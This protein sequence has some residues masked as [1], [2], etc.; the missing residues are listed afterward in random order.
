MNTTMNQQCIDSTTSKLQKET[1]KQYKTRLGRITQSMRTFL[2]NTINNKVVY[3][4]EKMENG[5]VSID[6]KKIVQKSKLAELLSEYNSKQQEKIYYSPYFACVGEFRHIILY[7]AKK[8]SSNGDTDFGDRLCV[9]IL[10]AN[11]FYTYYYLLITESLDSKISPKLHTNGYISKIEVL[12]RLKHDKPQQAQTFQNEIEK[13]YTEIGT[14]VSDYLN[15]YLPAHNKQSNNF[16]KQ[17]LV[18]LYHHDKIYY[19]EQKYQEVVGFIFNSKNDFFSEDSNRSQLGTYHNLIGALSN[20]DLA[21]TYRVTLDYLP[22]FTP[23]FSEKYDKIYEEYLSVSADVSISIDDL[24]RFCYEHGLIYNVSSKVKTE[25]KSANEVNKVYTDPQT[26]KETKWTEYETSYILKP[27]PEQ[28]IGVNPKDISEIQRRSF[29]VTTPSC[30]ITDFTSTK[31]NVYSTEKYTTKANMLPFALKYS[32]E[33]SYSST[34]TDG[35]KSGGSGAKGKRSTTVLKSIYSKI[36]KLFTS[37]SGSVSG[38]SDFVSV[39]GGAIKK[40][41]LIDSDIQF[42]DTKGFTGSR[43]SDYR[44]TY[45]KF[46]FTINGKQYYLRNLDKPSNELS[47]YNYSDVNG[48][49]NIIKFLL[50]T[51]ADNSNSVKDMNKKQK[52]FSNFNGIIEYLYKSPETQESFKMILKDLESDTSYNQISSPG[53]QQPQYVQ[54]GDSKV[55]V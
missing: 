42:N 52:I 27:Y 45:D 17:I 5:R 13:V 22:G 21:N 33:L 53:Q 10:V 44:A 36:E 48:I 38:F 37:N 29:T 46:Y 20:F 28:S 31:E 7:A 50:Y 3:L 34:L 12:A 41:F 1:D 47:R 30:N 49:Y 23:Y 6:D 18:Q 55:Y 54:Q 4:K 16:L 14:A 8:L 11:L 25:L 24:H 39:G 19:D 2:N 26:G 15:I 35:T 32:F 9:L 51:I 40:V 43:S